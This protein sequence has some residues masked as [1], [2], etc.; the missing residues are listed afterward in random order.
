MSKRYNELSLA[1][2]QILR[3][4]ALAYPYSKMAGGAILPMLA[5]DTYTG[6]I[7]KFDKIFQT[8][9]G[10]GIKRAGGAKYQSIFTNVG[11]ETYVT[12]RYG[13]M[14][15]VDRAE[16]AIANK[17]VKDR[18]LG[19]KGRVNT[20]LSRNEN[21]IEYMRHK[22]LTDSSNYGDSIT[23]S[24]TSMFSD[25]ACIPRDIV[26]EGKNKIRNSIGKDPNKMLI[27]YSTYT[28][29][30]T[31]ADVVK[32]LGTAGKQRANLE[33]LK[34]YF[35]VEHIE[36]GRSFYAK[37][38]DSDDFTEYWNSVCVLAYVA[39]TPKKDEMSFGYT[40]RLNGNIGGDS[41]PMIQSF[42][43]PSSSSQVTTLDDWLGAMIT[44]PSAGYLIQGTV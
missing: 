17:T 2:Q 19:E 14:F 41:Y 15:P 42:Y 13:E 18:L 5:V 9:P 38:S 26:Q 32:Y 7:P 25:P 30:Q 22:I 23:L 28:T 33:D 10:E 11:Y 1:E 39:E 27:D 35:E 43:D 44:A 21:F 37:A 34:A 3:D 8:L 16:M 4:I 29:L 20:L 24:G 12:E 6:K 31:Q 40:L 36:V